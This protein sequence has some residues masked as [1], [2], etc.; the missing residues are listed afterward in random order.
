M[1]NYFLLLIFLLSHFIKNLSTPFH[2]R[3]FPLCYKLPPGRRVGVI[4]LPL[5]PLSLMLSYLVYYFRFI[6]TAF[7]TSAF[8]P[9]PLW[10]AGC[11]WKF[12]F[13]LKKSEESA[14]RWAWYTTAFKTWK[15]NL[16]ASYYHWGRKS[17]VSQRRESSE[18][19]YF[20]SFLSFCSFSHSGYC[21]LIVF[22]VPNGERL[23]ENWTEGK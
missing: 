15:I 3:L 10:M 18:G 7:L 21:N 5:F 16:K 6:L 12:P 4:L 11:L 20:I 1:S 2:Y 17:R 8:F 23:R 13:L 9:H 14:V 22:T 19:V